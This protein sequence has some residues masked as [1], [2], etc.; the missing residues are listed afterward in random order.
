[1]ER[2]ILFGL[3]ALAR[4]ASSVLGYYADWLFAQLV[5][6]VD[7]ALDLVG[8]LWRFARALVTNLAE[9]IVGRRGR[10]FGRDGDGWEPAYYGR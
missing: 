5:D 3:G 10:D 1:M 8:D 2:F 7:G 4:A 6:G 9:R